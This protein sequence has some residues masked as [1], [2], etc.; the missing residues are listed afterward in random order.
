[1]G[2]KTASGASGNSFEFRVQTAPGRLIDANSNLGH[3][4]DNASLTDEQRYELIEYLK[5][6]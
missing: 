3:D 4:Y 6:L 2:F 1:M 5:R